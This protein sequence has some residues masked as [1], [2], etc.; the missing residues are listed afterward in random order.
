MKDQLK[1]YVRLRE[2]AEKN[3]YQGLIFSLV[4]VGIATSRELKLGN[5]GIA[6]GG[7]HNGYVAAFGGL[8]VATAFARF[9]FPFR[10]AVTLRRLLRTDVDSSDGSATTIF[11][12][13]RPFS[14]P[15]L[16]HT[17]RKGL[18][19]APIA[20]FAALEMLWTLWLFFGFSHNGESIGLLRLLLTH[21]NGTTAVWKFQSSQVYLN[22]PF[23][24]WIQLA[25]TAWLCRVTYTETREI[26][27]LGDSHAEVGASK[28]ANSKDQQQ[29]ERTF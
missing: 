19:I 21:W 27:S 3:A 6:D 10:E 24:T 13:R 9:Y 7:F 12:L 5:F 14:A 1:E 8:L 15:N 11:F 20:I 18:M 28:R 17:W 4:L 23:H 22:T 25:L 16:S 2:T 26:L 29:A